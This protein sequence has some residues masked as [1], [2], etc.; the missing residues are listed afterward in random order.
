MTVSDNYSPDVTIG[1]GATTVF[2]G[3]WSPLVST[4][5]RVALEL[6]S[7]GVQTL[8]TQGVD[9]T[10]A[11]TS[12]GY[13]VTMTTAPSALYNVVRYREVAI[14]QNSPY[15]T[16]QGF[17][18]LTIEQSF[19][20]L[21]AIAQDQQDAVNRS[22]AFAVGSSSTA[23]LPEPENGKVLGWDNTDLVNLTPNT[24]AYIDPIEF[25]YNEFNVK[26]YGALG[27]GS[28]NDYTAIQAAI[29]AAGVSG[30]VVFFPAGNYRIGT[31]LVV[32]GDK[33]SLR[34]E[35]RGLSVIEVNATLSVA[36]LFNSCDYGGFFDMSLAYN[37]APSAG[38]IAIKLIGTNQTVLNNFALLSTRVG[39]RIGDDGSVA[40]RT[41]ISDFSISG[42]TEEAGIDIIDSAFLWVSDGSFNGGNVANSVAIR[43]NGLTSV[44]GQVEGLWLARLISEQYQYGIRVGGSGG[45]GMAN[46]HITDC[47][48][49]GTQTAGMFVDLQTPGSLQQVNICN[50]HFASNIGSGSSVGVWLTSGGTIQ[51]IKFTGCRIQDYRLQG[52]RL[53]NVNGTLVTFDACSILNN[54]LSASGAASAVLVEAGVN[55]FAI[56]DC[57]INGANHNY[58]IEVTNSTTA[59]AII[60]N[61]LTNVVT[62]NISLGGVPSVSCLIEGNSPAASNYVGDFTPVVTFDTAG[63]LSVTYSSQVGKWIRE[64]RKITVFYNIV[65][66]AFTHTTASGVLRITGLPFTSANVTNQLFVGSIMFGGI[67]K[68]GYTQV[69]GNVN[70]NESRISIAASGSG[71]AA[72]AVSAAD[73]PTGGTLTLRGS[74]SYYI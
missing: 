47:I 30:G 9:Y 40:T 19:D 5:M 28:T 34:G 44:T 27:D 57:T 8:Q 69:V 52:V 25:P 67:T 48:F 63:N 29:T 33:V 18:G 24:N 23:T 39:L 16:S 36:L 49:D 50:T 53:A 20:K 17:Q 14:D 4:N 60:G 22:I 62:G 64:G 32:S 54:S 42:D 7:T 12:S 65:T 70:P 71:V 3:S 6:I 2:T 35:G 56:R 58:A 61:Q 15:S 59:F 31:G 66:S 37:V 10:L 74:V 45:T 72:S 13:S 38:N 68:A 46:W 26:D 73:C 21:T 51:R 41:Y 11:F 55:D 1:N 43:C